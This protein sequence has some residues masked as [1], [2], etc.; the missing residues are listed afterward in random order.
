MPTFILFQLITSVFGGG[1]FR[2]SQ[3]ANIL[4]RLQRKI[5]KFLF[6]QF[7]PTALTDELFNLTGI[8]K[9]DLVYLFKVASLMYKVVKLNKYPTLRGDL[10]LRFPPHLYNTRR[11]DSFILPFFRTEAIRSNF[12]Y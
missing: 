10:D 6:S 7:F 8:M 9:L 11:N 4:L 12:N 5:I 2:C 1:V 3:R